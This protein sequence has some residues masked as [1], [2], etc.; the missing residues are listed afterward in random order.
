MSIE[1][2]LEKDL[3]FSIENIETE[4][5]SDLNCRRCNQEA[6]SKWIK[7][8]IMSSDYNGHIGDTRRRKESY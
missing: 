8:C 3:D 4:D 6:S 2:Y 7:V 5:A 1:I